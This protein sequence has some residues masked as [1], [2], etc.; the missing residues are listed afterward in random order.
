MERLSCVVRDAS[1]LVTARLEQVDSIVESTV[2]GLERTVA[3]I[4]RTVTR[5]VKEVNGLAAGIS[6]G[7]S[8]FVHGPER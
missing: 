7:I 4:K 6:A 3:A 8:T 1:I 5:P 2:E